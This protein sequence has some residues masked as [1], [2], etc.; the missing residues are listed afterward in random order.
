MTTVAAFCRISG[1]GRGNAFIPSTTFRSLWGRQCASPPRIFTRRIEGK[2][3]RR[4]DQRMP[5]SRSSSV[6]MGDDYSGSTA[7][8][9]VLK[10]RM[11]LIKPAMVSGRSRRS[12]FGGMSGLRPTLAP[13]PRITLRKW[14]SETPACQTDF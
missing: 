2:R 10:A 12:G 1:S 11:I 13:P 14:R 4:L 5:R 3:P 7:P 6:V 9:G 8:F